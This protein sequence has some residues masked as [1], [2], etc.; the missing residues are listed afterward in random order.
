MNKLLFVFTLLTFNAFSQ[1]SLT[2][3]LGEFKL[4]EP[5]AIELSLTAQQGDEIAW[6]RIV[7]TLASRWV[8][9][10]T[11]AI[12]TLIQ[13]ADITLTQRFTITRFDTTLA[14]IKPLAVLVNGDSLFSDPVLLK[15]I[16]P[17]LSGEDYYD[18]KPIEDAPTNW[19]KILLWSG[20]GL[21]VALA[22]GYVLFLVLRRKKVTPELHPTEVLPPWEIAYRKLEK[23]EMELGGELDQ[24]LFYIQLTFI[25]REYL[26]E[27][28]KFPALE[29][30]S[31]ELLNHLA[32]LNIS[33]EQYGY[34]DQL[35]KESDLIKFAK[36]T[37][38]D[39]LHKTNIKVVRDFVD[40]N[41]PIQKEDNHVS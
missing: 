7:D 39:D 3:E 25:F 13:N 11:M 14:L 9:I 12:D 16:K 21:A 37:I 32:V 40:K 31:T 22:L 18:I 23:L 20:I 33:P 38:S 29:S 36:L 1:V 17:T 30:T 4:G 6:P 41:R 26:E 34:I 15:L 8:V 2:P 35:L 5:V 27:V 10:D 24:K 28:Y 19:E